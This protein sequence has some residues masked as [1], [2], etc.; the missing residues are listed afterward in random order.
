[1][2]K[3]ERQNVYQVYNKIATWFAANRPT[4]LMEKAYLDEMISHLPTQATVLDVGCG[5]GDPILKYLISKKLNVTGLDASTQ[6]LQIAKA[7]FPSVEFILQDMRLL[8]LNRRFDAIVAWHSFF[9]LPA[10]DQPAMFALFAQHLNPDGILLFTSGTEHGEAWGLNGG[11]NLYHASLDSAAYES[12]LKKHHFRVLKHVVNDPD[13]G[14][15]TIWMTKYS[16]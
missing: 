13:C 7:N 8:N 15:D 2:N 4:G 5:T 1:M 6:I 16:L 10:A 12:V 3:G 14:Y 9:H 11:E